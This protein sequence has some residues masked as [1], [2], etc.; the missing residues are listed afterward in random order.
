MHEQPDD[1]R[2]QA[3]PTSVKAAANESLPLERASDAHADG[4][5]VAASGER[6]SGNMLFGALVGLLAGPGVGAACCWLCGAVD[7]LWIGVIVGAAVGVFAGALIAMAER[8][9]RGALARPDI[10]TIICA[11]FGLAPALVL[12]P[13]A[14]LSVHGRFSGFMFFGIIAAGP[15]SGLLVGAMLDRA[16]EAFLA[17]TWWP[18]LRYGGF[19]VAGCVGVLVAFLT[20]PWAPEPAEIERQ[21]RA[22]LLSEWRARPGL[23]GVKIQKIALERKGARAYT[24]FVEAAVG[25]QMERFVLDVFYEGDGISLKLRDPGE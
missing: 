3:K 6:S 1:D 7:Y 10:A 21:A 22:L 24:G 15:M 8:R 9:I 18:A 16:H 13:N 11:I 2:I 12:I 20:I 4:N 5:E 17:R 19:G 25:G 14:L 23:K